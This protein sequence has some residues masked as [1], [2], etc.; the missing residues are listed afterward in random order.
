[1]ADV[2]VDLVDGDVVIRMNFLEAE[3]FADVVLY[4]FI[5][6]NGSGEEKLDNLRAFTNALVVASNRGREI[7]NKGRFR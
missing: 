1:M 6:E 5:E 4:P 7:A 2:N 3:A